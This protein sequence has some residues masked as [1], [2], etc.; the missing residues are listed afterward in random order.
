MEGTAPDC[1][2]TDGG[3]EEGMVHTG[4]EKNR[5]TTPFPPERHG[6]SE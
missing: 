4:K 5:G 2:A 6:R 3:L 1:G